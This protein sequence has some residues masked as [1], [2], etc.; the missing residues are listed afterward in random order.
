ME[1]YQRVKQASASCT[2]NS[3]IRKIALSKKKQTNPK[4]QQELYLPQP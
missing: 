4:K 2:G 3:Q 1:E